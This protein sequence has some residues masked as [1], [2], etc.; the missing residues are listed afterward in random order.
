M[1]K[2]FWTDIH[3]LRTEFKTEL[4]EI[5]TDLSNVQAI[6]LGSAYAIP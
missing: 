4:N 3:K 2:R 5:R 6:A 1:G